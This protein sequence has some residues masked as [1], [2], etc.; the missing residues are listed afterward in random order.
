[1]AIDLVL[2]GLLL[3]GSVSAL[4]SASGGSVVGVGGSAP[5]GLWCKKCVEV[6]VPVLA[7]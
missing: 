6:V 4:P 5:T 7:K 2:V 3:G 1:M